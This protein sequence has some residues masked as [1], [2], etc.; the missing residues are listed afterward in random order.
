KTHGLAEFVAQEEMHRHTGYWWSPDAKHIAYEEADHTGVEVWTIADPFKPGVK[1]PEQF[2]PRPGKK[3]VSV[4]LGVIPVGGGETV[5]VE[6]PNN[7]AAHWL[8]VKDRATGGTSSEMGSGKR[9]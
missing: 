9:G 5:W 2:Y 7:K 6:W 1:P 3:N 8:T 4:R